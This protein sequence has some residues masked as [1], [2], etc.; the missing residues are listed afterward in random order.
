M[1]KHEI[2]LRSIL[3]IARN[4]SIR[5]FGVRGRREGFVLAIAIVVFSFIQKADAG[6]LE[7]RQDAALLANFGLRATIGATCTA[8]DV[9]VPAGTVSGKHVACDTITAGNV[10]VEPPGSDFVAG[11]RIILNSGFS[12]PSGV[13]F[14]ARI[15]PIVA[16]PLAY[17][18]DDRPTSEATYNAEFHLRLNGLTLVAGDEIGH[19]NGYAAN[20]ER[21]FRV[22][23]RHFASE[24][25]LAIY[26]R[27]DTAGAL[28]EHGVD[29]HLTSGFH[30]VELSW[31]ADPGNGKF[32]VSIDGA[33]F[34]GLTG[35]DNGG[36]R[37]DYVRWGAADGTLTSSTGW[38]ELD[39]FS[40]WR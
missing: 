3:P 17:L 12:V 7:V 13:P 11:S 9:E 35:L 23:L 15:D 4:Q 2:H 10:E 24:N 30:S 38:M 34:D 32:M 29:F 36:S 1:P 28:V 20:G 8:P 21:Q 33:S 18:T 19:F 26:A 40:S 22:T 5:A 39:G 14:A 25:R 6:A 31:E 37:V 27:D 16:S